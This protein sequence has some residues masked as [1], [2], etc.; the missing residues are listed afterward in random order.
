LGL[1]DIDGK[2]KGILSNGG[3]VGLGSEGMSLPPVE[4]VGNFPDLTSL[5]AGSPF[6]PFPGN[7]E[8]EHSSRSEALDPVGGKVEKSINGVRKIFSE[9]RDDVGKKVVTE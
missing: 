4:A 7:G 2:N 1:V 9:R 5:P 3:R 8:V 6:D